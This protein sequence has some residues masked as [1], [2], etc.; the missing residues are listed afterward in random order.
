VSSPPPIK[1]IQLAYHVPSPGAAAQR[2][3]KEHGWG[4]FFLMEHIPLAWAR[5]RGREAAFDHSSAYGQAGDV[6]I[7]FICQ[8]GD[9]PSALRD[10]YAEDASGIH[11]VATFVPDVRAAAAAYAANGY[12]LALEARTSTGVEFTMV[13]TRS[14]FGHMLEIY[15]PGGG[16]EKFYEFVRKASVG[17]DGRDPLRRL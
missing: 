2:A 6:M 8:H 14:R 3:A 16:L 7:E 17:W 12:E 13:D 10:M 11:H 5:H 1:P 4:P 9:A 15:E